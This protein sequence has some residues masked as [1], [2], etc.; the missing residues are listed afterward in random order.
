MLQLLSKN[1]RKSSLKSRNGD[2]AIISYL[3]EVGQAKHKF[4]VKTYDGR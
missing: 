2:A 3:L 4:N 1:K